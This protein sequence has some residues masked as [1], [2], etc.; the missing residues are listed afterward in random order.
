MESPRPND[1]RRDPAVGAMVFVG[2]WMV[3]ILAY[4]VGVYFDRYVGFAFVLLGMTIA[5]AGFVMNLSAVLE[6]LGRRRKR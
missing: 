6:R 5:L 1:E 4:F 3:G 2:G